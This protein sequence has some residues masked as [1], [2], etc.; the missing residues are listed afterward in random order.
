MSECFHRVRELFEKVILR[1]VGDIFKCSDWKL[2]NGIPTNHF[3]GRR[4]RRA[5]NPAGHAGLSQQPLRVPA[6]MYKMKRFPNRPFEEFEADALE[7]A[8]MVPHT[9]RNSSRTAMR[10]R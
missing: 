6:G 5:R 4:A 10:W 9:E 3:S 7:C 1:A 2:T 8:R